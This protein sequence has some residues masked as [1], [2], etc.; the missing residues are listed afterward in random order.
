VI[1]SRDSTVTW[2]NDDTTLH[3]VTSGSVEASES[4][5]IFDSSY[6]AGG[7]TFEWT[8]PST[9]TFDYLLYAS[10]IYEWK[11]YSEVRMVIPIKWNIQQH[12]GIVERQQ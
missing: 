1:L 8:F 11:N 10:S 2:I 4:G 12:I 9:G 5:T 3:T 6:M 7:S